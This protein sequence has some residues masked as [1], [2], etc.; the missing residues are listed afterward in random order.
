MLEYL[1]SNPL[2]DLMVYGS[3][4]FVFHWCV[5]RHPKAC[6]VIAVLAIIKGLHTFSS[7]ADI[8]KLDFNKGF[9]V[10]LSIGLYLSRKSFNYLW[11]FTGLLVIK[12]FD[13]LLQ[14]L[15]QSQGSWFYVWIIFLDALVLI[16]LDQRHKFVSF[17]ARQC[18]GG[19]SYSA[20]QALPLQRLS[21][22]EVLLMATYW[23]YI[24][25]SLLM[26]GEEVIFRNTQWSPDLIYTIYPLVKLPLNLFELAV[27]FNIATGHAI[28][29]YRKTRVL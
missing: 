13:V 29:F 7:D 24:V 18:W 9:F 25:V 11:L 17:I 8:F 3:L 20:Q 23:V 6:A 15:F 19:F 10:C 26:L 16:L 14:P 28:C 27:L 12:F 4:L 21:Y 1:V 2:V 22:Q 5:Y